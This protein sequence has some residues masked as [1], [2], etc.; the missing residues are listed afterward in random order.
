MPASFFY[1]HCQ[2]VKTAFLNF[3]HLNVNI[4]HGTE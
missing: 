1:L 4:L 2:A 3:A